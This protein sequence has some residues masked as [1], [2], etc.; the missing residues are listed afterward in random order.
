MLV[1][2]V[3]V[4][5]TVLHWKFRIINVCCN[6]KDASFQHQRRLVTFLKQLDLSGVARRRLPAGLVGDSHVTVKSRFY[7]IVSG[8]YPQTWLVTATGI[9][10]LIEIVWSAI[11]LF[12]SSFFYSSLILFC[13]MGITEP[14]TVP[15]SHA[16][17]HNRNAMFFLLKKNQ[18]DL[19]QCMDEWAISYFFRSGF[20]WLSQPEG[21]L[22]RKTY[23]GMC[24][25]TR[26]YFTTPDQERGLENRD[27]F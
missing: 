4:V 6:I 14:P 27:V 22:P 24:H 5:N 20:Y 26:L 23:M 17:F 1:Q 15:E 8:S 3:F 13:G 11:D 16:L 18:R 12:V 25:P 9:D 2:Y 7:Q 21:L 19:I 10:W